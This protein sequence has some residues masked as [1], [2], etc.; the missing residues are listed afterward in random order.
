M[1]VRELFKHFSYYFDQIR[2]TDK[3]NKIDD[4]EL[5]SNLYEIESQ[6]ANFMKKYGHFT[7]DDW[8]FDNGEVNAIWIVIS[9][10]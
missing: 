8:K 9:E 1:T 4:F 5:M 10:E 2:Y 3:T 6:Y 7:V